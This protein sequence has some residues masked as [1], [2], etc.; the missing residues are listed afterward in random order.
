MAAL[1]LSFLL[2]SASYHW[3]ELPF[4]AQKKQFAARPTPVPGSIVGA[5]LPDMI[6]T[7]ANLLGWWRRKSR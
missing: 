1:M 4:L 6:L 7:S 3:I 5:S 2:A